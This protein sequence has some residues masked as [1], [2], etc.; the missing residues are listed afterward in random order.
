MSVP[1]PPPGARWEQAVPLESL[2]DTAGL[3]AAVASSLGPGD[4]LVLTGEL[5]AGKTTF[6]QA[7]AQHLGVEHQVS[8]PTFVMARIHPSLVSGPDLVHVDV[9]R[10]QDDGAASLDLTATLPTSVTVVEWGRGVVEHDLLGP[11]GSW[12]DLELRHGHHR[13]ETLESL[14]S[15]Q[16]GTDGTTLN[17][18]AVDGPARRGAAA[19]TPAANASAAPVIR[20]DFSETEEDLTGTPRTAVLRGYGPRWAKPPLLDH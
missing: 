18:S 15:E 11:H 2:A 6:T 3:A 8:S 16:S 13:E 20:T 4:V 7:L 14:E 17:T 5:G 12:L 10:T 9:Y 1:L 19:E